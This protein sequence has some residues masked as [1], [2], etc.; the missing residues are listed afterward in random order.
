MA[1]L[2]LDVKALGLSIG[3]LWGSA[4]LLTGFMTI[5]F[6]WGNI[7]VAVLSSIYIGYKPT[8]LGSLIGG[9][10]GFF[11]AGIG[12]VIVAWLYNKLSS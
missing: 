4:V 10:W 6:D 7:F 12:G 5:F 8:I 2:K 9:V 11:D 1:K 3:I